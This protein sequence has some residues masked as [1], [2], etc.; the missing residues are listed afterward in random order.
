[1]PSFMSFLFFCVVKREPEI[2]S[3]TPIQGEEVTPM[4]EIN[5]TSNK[6]RT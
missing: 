5:Q 1:M 4:T 3:L 2:L 6:E